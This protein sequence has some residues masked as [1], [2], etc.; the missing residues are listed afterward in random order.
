M[1]PVIYSL[2]AL[3]SFACCVLLWR[4]WRAGGNRLLLWSA[5]CFAGL[6]VN[7]LL[8]V[9]DK[10]VLP[11]EVDLYTSRLVSAL[12]AVSLLLFGLVWEEE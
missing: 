1:A 2:C 5:L 4:G 10:V 11:A 8:L 3:T 12:V 9:I 7:N 6:T